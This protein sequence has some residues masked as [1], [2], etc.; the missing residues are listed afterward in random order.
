MAVELIKQVWCD[1]H[2]KRDKEKVAAADA[3]A[4][5]FVDGKFLQIDTC[6]EHYDTL[7]FLEICAYGDKIDEPPVTRRKR[8]TSDTPA[9]PVKSRRPRVQCSAC[10]RVVGTGPGWAL[11]SNS[12]IR[13]G[14]KVGKPLPV[15]E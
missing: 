3:V 5:V 7:T 11:H 1:M 9:A 13:R 8:N 14:E 2:L 15:E 10:D 6:Q 12:H 4:I